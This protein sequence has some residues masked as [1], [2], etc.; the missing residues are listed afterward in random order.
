MQKHEFLSIYKVP[1]FFHFTDER[2]LDSIRATGGLCSLARLR[3]LGIKPPASGGNDWSQDADA[4][5]G[6]DEYVHLC[7]TS[8]HPMEWVARQEGRIRTSRFLQ[9]DPKVLLNEGIKLC[10]GVSNKSDVPILDF[11]ESLSA[12][13]FQ[14]IY[15]RTDWRDPEIKARRAIA[16]KYELLVPDFIPIELI[17]G[18]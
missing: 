11:E 5:Y 18:V 16:K 3:T 2:N 14:V 4:M 15:T 9:I 7:L 6:L 10:P 17:R 12:M 13:D 8:E 1:C